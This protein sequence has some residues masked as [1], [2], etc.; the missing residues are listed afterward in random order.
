MTRLA[1][2]RVRWSIYRG[3]AT[4]LLNLV[5]LDV[6]AGQTQHSDRGHAP[7]EEAA[8]CTTK[9]LVIEEQGDFFVGGRTISAPA[10]HSD[11]NAPLPGSIVVDQVWVQYQ[12]PGKCKRD[13]PIVMVHGSWH[14]G[15]TYLST[16][17]GRE[18]WRTYF[19]RRGFPTYITD[20]VNRGRSSMDMTQHNLV[21]LGLAGG[22][23]LPPISRRSNE[24]S[25][26][27]FR[28][29]PKPGVSYPESQFP[30]EA[31]EQYFAQL[32]SM[33]RGPDQMSKRIEGLIS[34]LETVGPAVLVTHSSAGPIGWAATTARPDLVRGVVSIEPILLSDFSKFN[35]LSSTPVMIMRGDFDP[36]ETIA[37]AE[38]FVRK[39]RE[40]GVNAKFV[41][42]P[43]EGIVGN[44]HMLMMDRNNLQVADIVIS[45]IERNVE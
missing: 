10:T 34:V 41:H 36:P 35:E 12:V 8:S 20:D 11:G 1:S 45:W 14:T 27:R 17:D 38:A 18:G 7:A 6:A 3:L 9:H 29:G 37:D 16:P 31:Q 13:L 32:T 26:T 19:V 2:L 21:R 5:V 28:M 15:K 30:A 39:A 23:T 44:S 43:A 33:Y 24:L 40:A 25:W 42:L 4:I 22:G